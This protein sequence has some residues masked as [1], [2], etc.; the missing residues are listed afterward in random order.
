MIHML[1]RLS[2]RGCDGVSGFQRS[3]SW[4][5]C[6]AAGDRDPHLPTIRSIAQVRKVKPWCHAASLSD[7]VNF[8]EGYRG[9]FPARRREI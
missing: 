8:L 2:H 7:N 9:V 4:R 6:S 1:Y 3:R 5:V